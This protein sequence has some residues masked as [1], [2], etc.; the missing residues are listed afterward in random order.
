MNKLK[1][2]KLHRRDAENAEFLLLTTPAA[3][4]IIKSFPLRLCASAVKSF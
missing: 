2:K 3:Q 1:T 4:L